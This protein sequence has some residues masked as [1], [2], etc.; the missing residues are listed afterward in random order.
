MTAAAV[1]RPDPSAPLWT[2]LGVRRTTL[3]FY[4]EAT[5]EALAKARALGPEVASEIVSGLLDAHGAAEHGRTV[6]SS[7][8][9]Q[10]AADVARALRLTGTIPALVRCLERLSPYDAVAHAALRA[11]EAMRVEATE[12]LLESFA[13]CACAED[14]ILG[15]E[16]L[17][18]AGVRDGRIRV[19]LTGLLGESPEDAAGLLRDHGDRDAIPALVSA[20][21][22]LELLPHG[23]PGELRRCEA[24][25]AIVQ[26]IRAL[27]GKVSRPQRAKFDTAWR[28]S[29]VL[30]GVWPE[31]VASPPP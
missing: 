19:A 26:A 20:L 4:E 29:S 15:A 12:P 31:T 10:R 7:R 2:L 1:C 24:I 17:V 27:R 21:D 14:R 3:S 9:A 6:E 25:V 23:T 22:G 18:R 16:A 11:L 8:T 28:R 5:D 30:M 13:R